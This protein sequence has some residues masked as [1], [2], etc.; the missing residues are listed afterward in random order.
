MEISW[1]DLAWTSSKGRVRSR[2]AI[3]P[4]TIACLFAR[5]RKVLLVSKSPRTDF[6]TN[7]IAAANASEITKVIEVGSQSRIAPKPPLVIGAPVAADAARAATTP[8]SKTP[9]RS[10]RETRN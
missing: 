9:I 8:R 2:W 4:A 5:K 3:L 10:R 6:I 1:L 7:T